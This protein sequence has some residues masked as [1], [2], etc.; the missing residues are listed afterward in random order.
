MSLMIDWIDWIDCYKYL[1]RTS[2]W[3]FAIDRQFVTIATVAIGFIALKASNRAR[4]AI[5]KLSEKAAR[6]AVIVL[7]W[8]E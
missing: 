7:S 2:V 1:L 3:T 5:S 6:N 8:K 4:H